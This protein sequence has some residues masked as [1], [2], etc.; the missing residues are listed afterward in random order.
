MIASEV[1]ERARCR[2]ITGSR[3]GPAQLSGYTFTF[4]RAQSLSQFTRPAAD[5]QTRQRQTEAAV[6]FENTPF[7]VTSNG[8]RNWRPA[9]GGDRDVRAVLSGRLHR[10]E[11]AHQQGQG[12]GANT[13][14]M[15]SYLND[16]CPGRANHQQIRT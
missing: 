11:P 8:L 14:F 16:L 1:A 10:C 12:V 4:A 15:I 3:L 5:V 6:I 13:L 7:A 9:K 2:T